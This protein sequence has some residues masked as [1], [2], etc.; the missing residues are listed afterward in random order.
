LLVTSAFVAVVLSCTA[1]GSAAG[2]P[3]VPRGS[4]PASES[5]AGP[6]N[7]RDWPL[8]PRPTVVAGFDPPHLTYGS[9]HRGVDLA[10][11]LGQEVRAAAAGEV[12]YAG[13][14]G[15]KPVVVVDHGEVRTTYEP[16]WA[17]LSAGDRVEVGTP[18]GTLDNL[19][20]HC[21]PA[22]CLH[23]GLRRGEEYLD[24]LAWLGRA[25]V[26]LLPLW[27]DRP[28]TGPPLT[29]TVPVAPG[30]PLGLAGWTNQLGIPAGGAS[31]S[32]P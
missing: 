26:R 27:R 11:D 20:G 1:A 22:A 2:A 21:F 10:G 32:A 19:F 14:V 15:G 8:A 16:V 28:A 9:G 17:S 12:S 25:T 6:A 24:P 5:G 18:I 29:R 13:R 3:V 31:G 30:W 4:A 7:G 23:W